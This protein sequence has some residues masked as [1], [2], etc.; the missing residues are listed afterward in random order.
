MPLTNCVVTTIA[1]PQP[2]KAPS[3]AA[4]TTCRFRER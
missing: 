1:P 4:I 2:G 3:R